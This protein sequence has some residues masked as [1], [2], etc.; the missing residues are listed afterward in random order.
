MK[1]PGIINSN[2][3]RARPIINQNN[4]GLD[5]IVSIMAENFNY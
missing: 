5:K 4:S 1:N 3:N 2:R